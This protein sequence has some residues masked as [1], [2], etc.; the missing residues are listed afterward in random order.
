MARGNSDSV[1]NDHSTLTGGTVQ[2]LGQA[3]IQHSARTAP[4]E[5]QGEGLPRW[6]H[7]CS[8][9]T[10]AKVTLCLSPEALED[11]ARMSA[12]ELGAL[13]RLAAVIAHDPL[14]P[15]SHAVQ[16]AAASMG[17]D[18]AIQQTRLHG[19]LS[20]ACARTAGGAR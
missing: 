18:L 6:L 14:V 10:R 11:M 19:V 8:L 9:S 15:W 12:S 1:S 3:E 16:I 2:D 13:V 7:P 4:Q 5:H 20:R 17:D